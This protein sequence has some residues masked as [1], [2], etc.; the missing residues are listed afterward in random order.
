MKKN[1]GFQIGLDFFSGVLVGSFIGFSLDTFFN[2]KPYI[3]CGFMV[4]G[5]CAGINNVI[6]ATRKNKKDDDRPSTSVS[7]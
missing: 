4:L 6:R 5:F 7:N 2:T 1:S 3:L